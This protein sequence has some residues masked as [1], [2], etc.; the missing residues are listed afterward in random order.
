[1]N[2]RGPVG[3]ASSFW[4]NM[5][6]RRNPFL[7]EHPY[8]ADMADRSRVIPLGFHGDGGR[9]FKAQNLFVFSWNSLFATGS[10]LATRFVIT[11]LR[12]DSVV[13]ETWDAIARVIGWSLNVLLSGLELELD[14][15]GN[16]IVNPQT[17]YL[18]E[19]WRGAMTKVRGDWEFFFSVFGMP[20]WGFSF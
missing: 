9:F 11:V 16:P 12:K 2:V 18:A 10:T 17:G 20:N 7:I 15:Y 1:M 6:T 19:G 4:H 13:P 5:Q 8:L 14:A 3:Q